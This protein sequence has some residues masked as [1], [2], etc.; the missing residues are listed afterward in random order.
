MTGAPL[1]LSRGWGSP[2]APSAE[3]RFCAVAARSAE[4]SPR[5]EEEKLGRAGHG[6]CFPGKGAAPQTAPSWLSSRLIRRPARDPF[7]PEA[8]VCAGD[9]AATA[10]RESR[11]LEGRCS[12]CTRAELSRPAREA[13]P[14]TRLRERAG[15]PGVLSSPS[16]GG[17]R[18][19]PQIKQVSVTPPPSSVRRRRSRQRVAPPAPS[20]QVD[21]PLGPLTVATTSRGLVRVAYPERPLDQVLEGL[22]DAVSPRI[23]EAPARLDPIRRELEEYFEGR[24]RQFETPIDW[25]LTR[26]FFRRVLQAT[27]AIDYGDVCTYSEVAARAGSERAVRATGNGLGSNPMPWWCPAI[28][29]CARAAVS[30]AI[31]AGSTARSSCWA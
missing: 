23:L 18:A 26:G 7:A 21:S 17:W 16:L 20:A 10:F 31:P 3:F 2:T 19:S 11:S 14:T 1:L 22:A 5:V 6:S 9:L 27:A 30:A 13:P 4:S 25:A 29:W 28:A 15:R 8:I 24:R 12:L